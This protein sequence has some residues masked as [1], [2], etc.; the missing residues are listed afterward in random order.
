MY[1]CGRE[2]KE[3]LFSM[4]DL[5]FKLNLS[6]AMSANLNHSSEGMLPRIQNLQILFG[7][8]LLFEVYSMAILV[9]KIS[10][11]GCKI[12]LDNIKETIAFL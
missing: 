2:R 10:R 6:K 4:N 1:N 7:L 9:V 12:R 5:P 8:L 3:L 11:E